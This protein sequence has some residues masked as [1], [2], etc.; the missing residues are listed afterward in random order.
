MVH[1]LLL[2]IYKNEKCLVL[3]CIPKTSFSTSL[4]GK[5][6]AYLSS[7]GFIFLSSCIP[8]EKMSVLHVILSVR[9]FREISNVYMN[10]LQ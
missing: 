4:S 2:I 10:L 8:H 7:F 5:K 6:I 3:P 9:T 1:S